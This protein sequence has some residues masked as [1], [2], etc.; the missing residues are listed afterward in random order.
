MGNCETCDN[1]DRKHS[2]NLVLI[3]PQLAAAAA[4]S[5]FP[6]PGFGNEIVREAAKK[7]GPFNYETTLPY[8]W[9]PAVELEN[10][11]VYVGQ[12]KDGARNGRGKQFWKDGSYYEGY[13]ENDMANGLGRV[14]HADGDVYEGEWVNDK[15][16]GKGIYLHQDGASY[17]GEWLND[18]QHGYGIERWIDGACYEGNF[19]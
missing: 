12:W 1:V 8:E 7:L 14:I 2:T 15:P 4:P 3:D 10:G 5:D 16:Q 13:W 19:I 17:T 18:K 9:K 6:V 11:D